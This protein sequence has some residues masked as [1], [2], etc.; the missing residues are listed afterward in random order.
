VCGCDFGYV[1]ANCST[2]CQCNK[3]SDC[4]GETELDHCIHCHNNTQVS[5]VSS[6][7]LSVSVCSIAHGGG[8]AQ[9]VATLV[10]STKLLYAGPG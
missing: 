7:A 1:G 9:L 8:L 4:L 5:H 10:G 2:E 6:T 3:H